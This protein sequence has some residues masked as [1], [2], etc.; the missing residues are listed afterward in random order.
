MLTPAVG[1]IAVAQPAEPPVDKSMEPAAFQQ[2][3][4]SLNV[5]DGKSVRLEATVVGNPPPQVIWFKNGQQL[6]PTDNIKV[7]Y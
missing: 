4:S 3:L 2:P 1:C 5:E 6:Y 7:R